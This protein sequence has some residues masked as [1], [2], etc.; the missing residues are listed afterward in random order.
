M[1]I[2]PIE[3]RGGGIES[4]C[5]GDDKYCQNEDASE[6][7]GKDS[8]PDALILRQTTKFFPQRDS[9]RLDALPHPATIRLTI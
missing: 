5:A 3:P 7:E 8:F 9:R 4:C 6:S 2:F 1:W